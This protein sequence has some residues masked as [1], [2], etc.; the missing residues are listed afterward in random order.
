MKHG[1][2]VALLCLICGFSWLT[3]AQAQYPTRSIRFIVPFP[4]DG[5]TD[6]ARARGNRVAGR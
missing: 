3:P 2:R 6:A 4:P 1:Y 5:G